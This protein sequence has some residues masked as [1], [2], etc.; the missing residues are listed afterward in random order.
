MEV[1]DFK[2][3]K[4]AMKSILYITQKPHSPIVDGGTQAINSLFNVLQKVQG[5]EI[6]YAPIFSINANPKAV[7]RIKRRISTAL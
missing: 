1:V 4:I 5:I 6:T 7:L 2:D 3:S